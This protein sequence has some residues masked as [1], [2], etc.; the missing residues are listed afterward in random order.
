MIQLLKLII[1]CLSCILSCLVSFVYSNFK[2]ICPKTCFPRN[3][4]NVPVLAPTRDQSFYTDSDTPPHLVAFT[5]TLGKRRTH[6]RLNPPPPGP[7]GG[8]A[9]CANGQLNGERCY[10]QK[11][12]EMKLLRTETFINFSLYYQFADVIKMSL[13]FSQVLQ[14]WTNSKRRHINLRDVE[15]NC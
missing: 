7:H 6:S 9:K 1:L 2:A 15:L 8:G 13:R 3:Y 4:L 10:K 14:C 12:I 11:E 5:I